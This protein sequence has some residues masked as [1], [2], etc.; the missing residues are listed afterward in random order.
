MG[1]L[2][3][4]PVLRNT[5]IRD[6]TQLLFKDVEALETM[7]SRGMIEEGIR[8]IG[9]EQEL[10]LI[11]H[12][13][14]PAMLVEEVLSKVQD[15]HFTTELAKF[16]LEINL[17]PLELKSNCFPRLEKE[18][19]RLLHKCQLACDQLNCM[20]LLTGILPTMRSKHLVMENMTDRERYRALNQAIQEMRRSPQKFHIQGTDELSTS[21]ESVMFESCNTSFQVHYQVGAA[22]FASYY[23]WAQTIAGPVLA[24]CT[25]SPLFL[26]KRLWSETRI[27]LFQQAT[28]TRGYQEEL[29]Q[30]SARVVFGDRW[31]KEEFTDF[32]KRDMSIYRPLV[33]ATGLPDS[34]EQLKNGEF[35][36]LRAFALFNG[37]IYRWNRPCYGIT[38]GKPHFRVENRYLPSGPSVLDEV[39]NAMFWTGLMN[40]LPREYS[41]MDQKMDFHEVRSNF[42]KAARHGLDTGFSW[43]GSKYSA[44]ELLLKELIPIAVEGLKQAD[45]DQS[46]QEKYL[47]ILR[48]RVEDSKTGSNWIVDSFNTLIKSY[49]QGTVVSAIAQAIVKR[50]QNNLPVNKWPIISEEEIDDGPHRY[51]RV[52]QVM[53]KELYTVFEEDLIDLVPNIMKWN[54]VRHML[55]ENREG[56]LVGL[57]TLGRLGKYYSERKDNEPVMVK[58]VMI[59][60]VFTV[61]PDTSTLEAIQV[62]L[63]KHIGCLPVLNQDKKLVGVVTEKDLLPVAASYLKADKNQ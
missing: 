21:S 31:M 2:N 38:N 44:R 20:P 60:Q 58:D 11:D 1:D 22:D 43:M 62:M 49:P 48:E 29:R 26:G 45:V 41:Q 37:T 17:D 9:A 52:D 51:G 4:L 47:S 19:Q 8:R 24:A 18:L 42:I 23:N 35:P 28:D 13:A 56:E 34:L 50:Q 57:V 5:D 7:V 53:S 16:N 6:Y 40:G 10:C 36:K 33:S 54:Q 32:I 63:Q 59:E 30:T 3:V 15:P 55:V 14:D 12:H 27:A 61:S 25:N 46:D 39:A